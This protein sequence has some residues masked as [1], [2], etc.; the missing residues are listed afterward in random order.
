MTIGETYHLSFY[1]AAAQQ[2]G[3]NGNTKEAWVIC[4]GTCAYTTP[5]PGVLE[6]LTYFNAD[7]GDMDPSYGDDTNNLGNYDPNLVLNGTD[8]LFKTAVVTNPEHGFT[9][10]MFESF[11]FTATSTTA[12]LSLLAYGTPQGQPPFSL[13]DGISIDTV[14]PAPVPE[15]TTWAMMLIGFGIIGGVM[16]TR[17]RSTNGRHA[18]GSQML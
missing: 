18:L 13:I 1:W 15:P 2:A 12:T 3:L 5:N 7:P 14:V 6:G 17:R 11:S 4:I 8:K 16:R 9:P 10:W